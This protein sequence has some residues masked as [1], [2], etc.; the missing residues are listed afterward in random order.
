MGA[1][2]RADLRRQLGALGF[3][4]PANILDSHPDVA[5]THES[6]VAH[7][8]LLTHRLS[9][10]PQLRTMQHGEFRLTGLIPE[11]YTKDFAEAARDGL[12]FAWRDF[13]RR[14]FAGRPFRRWAD[15]FQFPEV[16]P[17]LVQMFPRA[18]WVLI[19]RDGRDSA[20][21]GEKHHDKMRDR[22]EADAPDMDFEDHCVYWA[23]LNRQLIDFLKPARQVLRVRY[24]DLVLHEPRTVAE[25]LRF[26]ELSDDPAVHEFLTRK[27]GEVFAAHG[28][29]KDPKSSIGRWRDALDE[30]QL[31]IVER[32]QRAMLDEL[33]YR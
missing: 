12:M 14:R 8:L 15:K 31:A 1:L 18:H 19:V 28:T 30:Q 22:R 29:S 11:V 24:E 9:Y 6:N 32:T 20:L 23:R 3:D 5:L 16:V 21:S 13:Y 4:P 33:G 10:L 26:C 7:Y 27:S 25:L 17:D 2:G